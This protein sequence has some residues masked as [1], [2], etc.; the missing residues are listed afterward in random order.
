MT[1]SPLGWYM[2]VLVAVILVS[3]GAWMG[4]IGRKMGYSITKNGLAFSTIGILGLVVMAVFGPPHKPE[5]TKEP[6]AIMAPSQPRYANLVHEK[7]IEDVYET[8]FNHGER[9]TKDHVAHEGNWILR[10]NK[11]KLLTKE[12]KVAVE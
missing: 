8:Q 5:V 2:L 6:Q 11:I 12:R 4:H 1:Y 9:P 3:T 7:I 10:E